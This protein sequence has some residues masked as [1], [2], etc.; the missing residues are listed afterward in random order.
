MSDRPKIVISQHVEFLEDRNETRDS[1]DQALIR[2][3]ATMGFTPVTVS[4]ALGD[5]LLTWLGSV[6]P[7]G[8]VL[9][10][11]QDVGT[12]LPRDETEGALLTY[13]RTRTLPVLGICR[14]MQFMVCFDGG[15]LVPVGGHV[16]SLHPLIE[17]RYL[18]ALRDVV[19]SFHKTGSANAHPNIPYYRTEDGS[20]EAIRHKS[21]WEGW[22]RHRA[23]SAVQWNRP[24]ASQ[25][26]SISVGRA[27]MRAI[28]LAAGTGSRLRPLSDNKPKCL[29]EVA[30]KSL[31]QRQLEVLSFCG[32]KD[33]VLVGGYEAAQLK[34]FGLPV[35]V[36]AEFSTTNMVESLFCARDYMDRDTLISYGDIVYAPKTLESIMAATAEVNV[37]IDTNFLDYW[38]AR[39]E[40]YFDDLETLG[41]DE[42]GWIC[43]IGGK[44]QS[45]VDIQGQYMGLMKFTIR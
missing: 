33:I 36:N 7:A 29:V 2:W 35:V 1:I 25:T 24:H 13:A 26:S 44:P 16:G 9:S 43:E 41:I 20:I 42:D 39:T 34:V 19:N 23:R 32:V 18:G 15:D 14:G 21:F 40:D 10:G 30:G 37:A 38:K 28:I 12:C 8:V 3:V 22:M 11:G 27:I 31:L 5:D 4:N 17:K 6:S 45:L